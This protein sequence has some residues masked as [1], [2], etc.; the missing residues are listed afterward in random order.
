MNGEP[1]PSLAALGIADP[2]ERWAALGFAVAGG[3]VDLGGVRVGLGEP[4]KGIVWWTLLGVE[5]GE[6]DGL[7]A[8]TP[9]L[10]AA[11]RG[12]YV[13]AANENGGICTSTSPIMALIRSRSS[14]SGRAAR[15]APMRPPP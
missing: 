8:A 13:Y 2:P 5:V 7:A 12:Q 9:P 6:I 10:A 11:P 1:R 14:R 15:S 4:G 3:G